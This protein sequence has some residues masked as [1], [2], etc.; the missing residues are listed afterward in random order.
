MSSNV[1]DPSGS[2]PVHVQASGGF[3]LDM[4]AVVFG[5]LFLLGGGGTSAATTMLGGAGVKEEIAALRTEV[6]GMRTDMQS[7]KT[8]EI[9]IERERAEMRA[10]INIHETRLDALEKKG[11]R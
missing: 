8:A 6:Q 3:N 2:H 1:N 5:A 11:T 7:N 10:T 9:F 4:R